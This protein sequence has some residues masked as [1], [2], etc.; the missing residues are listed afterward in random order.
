MRLGALVD[1]VDMTVAVKSD[2]PVR[3]GLE[4]ADEARQCFGKRLLLP[5]PDTHPAMQAGKGNS[6]KPRPRG[7]GLSSECSSQSIN[8]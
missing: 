6:Q 2:H 3:Q 1:P 5:E 8:C 7:S 4:G